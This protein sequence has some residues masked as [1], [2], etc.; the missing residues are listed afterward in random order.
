MSHSIH[1]I[2]A[3]AEQG[4]ALPCLS[5]SLKGE[6]A[7]CLISKFFIFAFLSVI[8]LFKTVPKLSAEVM[9]SVLEF[10]MHVF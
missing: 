7:I 3:K 2:S 1:T 5:L 8:L 10:R 4:D 6:F 9:P